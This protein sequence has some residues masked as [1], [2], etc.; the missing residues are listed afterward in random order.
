MAWSLQFLGYLRTLSLKFHKARTK[1]GVFLGLPSWLSQFSWDSQLGR[2]RKPPILVRAFWNFKRKVLKYPINCWLHATLI[3]NLVKPLN[4]TY[5]FLFWPQA[6]SSGPKNY[7]AVL[8][9]VSRT[10]F[11]KFTGICFLLHVSN[12]EKFLSFT[13][14]SK[15]IWVH[16]STVIY[17]FLSNIW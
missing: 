10:I 3:P 1:I 2:P 7:I 15:N 8:A 11:L 9:N 4:C 13:I 17:K 14:L 5:I 12:L 6:D 16:S